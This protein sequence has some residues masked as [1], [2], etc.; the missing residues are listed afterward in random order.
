MLVDVH[1]LP[2]AVLHTHL[3]PELLNADGWLDI[4]LARQVFGDLSD[5]E[6]AEVTQT[7]DLGRCRIEQG[8]YEHLNLR[9]EIDGIRVCYGKY[10]QGHTHRCPCGIEDFRSDE[11]KNAIES[12]GVADNLD[13]VKAHFREFIDDPVRQ[14][15]VSLVRMRKAEQPEHGGWRWHKWGEYIGTQQPMCEYL[16]D[17]PVIEEV[18]VF[19]IY[20]V[21]LPE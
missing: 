11:W 7:F 5:A 19:D 10:K 21:R 8:V 2:H 14:Y 4:T 12:D 17:E 15:V 13:Q 1:H 16:Y 9:N 6:F 20:E 18:C 3:R